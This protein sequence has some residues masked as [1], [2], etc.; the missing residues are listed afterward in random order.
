MDTSTLLR[1]L[2]VTVVNDTETALDHPTVWI[3]TADTFKAGNYDLDN[4][5]PTHGVY[6][7]LAVAASEILR[8]S[9]RPEGHFYNPVLT[10]MPVLS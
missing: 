7:S 10:Q 8:L 5:T 1:D 4:E 6:A 2:N 3:L 9:M